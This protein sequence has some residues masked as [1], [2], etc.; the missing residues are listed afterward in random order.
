[1]NLFKDVI[2][3][4][5]VTGKPILTEERDYVP[6]QV[7]VALSLHFDTVL[8]ANTMNLNSHI[9]K[10]M[11]YDYLINKVRHYKRPYVEWP[12]KLKLEDIEAIKEYYDVSYPK[13]KEYLTV[14]TDQEI[15]SIREVVSKGG[16]IK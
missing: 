2:P 3:S 13:A 11:Q 7:N 16:T 5:L 9:S 12:K 14:L 8:Y 6:F 1:M 15:G 10:K 4:I